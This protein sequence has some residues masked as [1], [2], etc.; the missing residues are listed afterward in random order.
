[1]NILDKIVGE[2]AREVL[3][4]EQQRP[5][6]ELNSIPFPEIRDFK[7]QLTAAGLSV[8]AEAKRKSPSAGIIRQNFD[9][10]AIAQS[11]EQHGASA[12]SVL[13]D[14]QFFGGSDDYP[15][16]IKEAIKLPVLRK[17][18]IIHPYQIVESR[19][20]GADAILLIAGVL[21]KFELKDFIEQAADLEMDCLVETHNHEELELALFA[22]AEIIG[23]NNRNLKTFEVDLNTSINL[24]KAIPDSVVTVSESGIQN[25][26]DFIKLGKAGFDAV[27]VGSS[28]MRETD[29]GLALHKLKATGTIAA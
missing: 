29:P 8:I 15:L 20:L 7:S 1:M 14:V 18:F 21:D 4:K 16:K 12:I 28:L 26:S 22:N 9:P 3:A 10:V 2:K 6:S 5:L 19:V 13:T 11:Y 23:I 17:E 25:S 24:K 27:L